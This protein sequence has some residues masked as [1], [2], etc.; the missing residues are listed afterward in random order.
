VVGAQAFLEEY[1]QRL[2]LYVSSVTPQ[3]ELRRIL[4]KRE[5]T[6]FFKKAFG[7]PPRTKPEAI[8][9]VLATHELSPSELLFV[10]D[11]I[12][13]YHAAFETGVVFIGRDSGQPFAGVEI[14]LFKDM[15]EI[16][17]ELRRRQSA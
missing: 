14:D 17:N 4:R 6:R 9:Q 2:P 7:D 8:R 1:Y 15:R 12:S 10:G 3:D 13:D 11:S 5:M 16:G